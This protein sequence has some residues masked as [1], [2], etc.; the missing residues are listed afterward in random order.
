MKYLSGFNKKLSRLRHDKGFSCED[1]ARLVGVDVDVVNA[2]ENTSD[3]QRSYPDLDNVIDL[4]LSASVSL[5][6]LL[7]VPEDEANFQL[8]L[9][10]LRFVEEADLSRSLDFLQY[11]IDKLIPTED[12]LEL[13]RRFRQCDDESRKLIIQLMAQ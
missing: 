9:P 10:G 1:I 11:E 6:E 3:E 7:T 5:D 2:W 4:C 13:L 8:E 12:E